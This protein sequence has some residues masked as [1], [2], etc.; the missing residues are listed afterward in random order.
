MPKSMQSIDEERRA[1]SRPSAT[2][3]ED[4]ARQIIEAIEKNHPRVRIGNDAKML[5][6]MIRLM[7]SRG[8]GII[9][10]NMEKMLG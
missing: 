8:I 1:E 2:R 5:D 6:R 4:A 10:K 7:P 9:K 3:P